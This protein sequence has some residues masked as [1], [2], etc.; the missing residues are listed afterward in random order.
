MPLLTD[1]SAF[2]SLAAPLLAADPQRNNLPLGLLQQAQAR[3]RPLDIMAYQPAGSETLVALRTDPERALILGG[4]VCPERLAGARLLAEELFAAQLDIHSVNGPQA[5]AEAFASSWSA[6]SGVPSRP[7]MHQGFYVLTQVTPPPAIAGH[8]RPAHPHELAQIQDWTWAF[9]Q[10]ALPDDPEL[11]S[12]VDVHTAEKIA[13]GQ[14]FVWDQAGEAVTMAA[15]QRPQD[16]GVCVSLVYTPPA[17]RKQGLAAACV[18]ALSQHLLDSGYRWCCL[19]TNLDN[20]TSNA[21]YERLGYVATESYL[22]ISLG[23][24]HASP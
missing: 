20:P 18:A 23:R 13:K 21:L 22:N 15:W 3:S 5:L 1:L 2:F 6:L 19:F 12:T 17:R 10:E 16:E 14:I 9:L 24:A 8:L 4:K 7:H 11:R